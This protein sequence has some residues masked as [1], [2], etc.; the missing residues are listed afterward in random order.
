MSAFFDHF[1]LIVCF[2]V[3]ET[4]LVIPTVC[5]QSSVKYV[6]GREDNFMP[7]S[8]I[9]DVIINEV[10]KMVRKINDKM[11]CVKY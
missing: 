8:S 11:H 3:P 7:W 5:I 2:Y 4:L 1:V 10:I 6:Y 9:D